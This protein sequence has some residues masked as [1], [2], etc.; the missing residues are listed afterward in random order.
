MKDDIKLKD[1]EAENQI[2]TYLL[3][4]SSE[5]NRKKLKSI[6]LK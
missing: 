5:D 6:L 2:I 4:G 1:I 3:N